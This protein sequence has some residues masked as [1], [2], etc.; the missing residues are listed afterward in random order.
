MNISRVSKKKKKTLIFYEDNIE[1]DLLRHYD[2]DHGIEELGKPIG[3]KNCLSEWE[4]LEL[5][6]FLSKKTDL[7]IQRGKTSI[8][9]SFPDSECPREI[10]L[11]NCKL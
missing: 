5:V 9:R 4:Y 11:V 6:I 10:V 1:N 3:P 8:L 2:W 7:D